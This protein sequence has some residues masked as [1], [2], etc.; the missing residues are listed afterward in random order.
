MLDIIISF[1]TV[2]GALPYLASFWRSA[3]ALSSAS[4]GLSPSPS[5][6]LWRGVPLLTVLFM[7]AVMLP[8]FQPHG[9]SIDRLNRAMAA[10]TLI[11]AAYMAETVRGGLQGVPAEQEEAAA[12]LGLGWWQMQLFVILPQAL[13]I[14]V[15][16]IVNNIV[17]LFKDTSL[18]S[19]ISLV[20]L[21]GASL[22]RR[23]RGSGSG[24]ASPR[25][26]ISSRPPCSSCAA[27]PCRAMAAA[28]SAASTD[29]EP[30]ERDGHRESDADRDH[31]IEGDLSRLHRPTASDAAA[32]GR[33]TGEPRDRG[34]SWSSLKTRA[35][36]N[37]AACAW[38]GQA[39]EEA[40]KKTVE[41]LKVIDPNSPQLDVSGNS[42][43]RAVPIRPT[44]GKTARVLEGMA[45]RRGCWRSEGLR[46]RSDDR[47]GGLR[48]GTGRE[49]LEL[50]AEAD[51]VPPASRAV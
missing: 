19:I 42:S 30:G 1:V 14:V 32:P 48:R 36:A 7:S 43:F 21:L 23:W 18:V 49:E 47:A 26:A 4:S 46:C 39:T 50:S 28:S 9:V 8:L 24:S 3:G 12:S 41:R 20:D 25:R 13:R 11:N 22:S 35:L 27:L 37:L 40:G 10:F 34:N 51:C 16:G 31:R 5:S 44:R 29:I 38:A 33:C 2:A 45:Q 15:P 6:S 17:D